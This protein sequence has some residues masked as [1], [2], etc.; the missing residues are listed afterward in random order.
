MK[1]LIGVAGSVA[2]LAVVIAGCGSDS[3]GSGDS[4]SAS[5]SPTV[6]ADDL[7]GTTYTS[8]SVEGHDLITGTEVV[9]GFEDG[10]LSVAAGCNTHSAPY[11]VDAATIR[12]TGDPASTMMACSDELSAQEEWVN[13]LFADGVTAETDG[14]RLTL[15]SGG[16]DVTIVLESSSS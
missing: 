4:A 1:K 16:D 3:E 9:L 5:A 6:T 7:E 11:E 10:S 15:T 8:T 14:S 12:W 13:G 2:V